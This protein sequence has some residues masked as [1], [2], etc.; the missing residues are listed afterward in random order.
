MAYTV[1]LRTLRTYD[2]LHWA[3]GT[4]YQLRQRQWNEK[5]QKPTARNIEWLVLQVEEM[6]DRVQRKLA[7]ERLRG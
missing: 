2:A 1:L 7:R 6:L 5:Y 3:A 4:E